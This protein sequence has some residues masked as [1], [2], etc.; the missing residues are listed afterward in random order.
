M[1][2]RFCFEINIVGCW[3]RCEESQT[4]GYP[5]RVGSFAHRICERKR[6]SVSHGNSLQQAHPSDIHNIHPNVVSECHR[7]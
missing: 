1:M 3:L 5:W 7:T 2:R 4:T 6:D